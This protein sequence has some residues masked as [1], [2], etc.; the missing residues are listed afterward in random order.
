[1]EQGGRQTAV[2]LLNMGGP[3]S[4]GAVRPFLQNL[5]SDPAIIGLPSL[6][7]GPLA[8]MMAARRARKVRP[9]YELI[10]GKSPIGPITFDQAAALGQA[11]GPAFGPVLPAFS[12]WRPFISDAVDEAARSG[13]GHIVALS[14][15]P[16][17]CMATTGSCLEDVSMNLP[18][19]PF[20]DSIHLIDSWATHPLY[21]DALTA[22][23][24]EA[25]FRVPDNLRDDAIILFSA[26]GVPESLI[27]GGDPYLEQTLATVEGV[28]ERLEGR[29]HHIAFQSRLGPVKW[30]RPSLPDKLKEL[31]TRGA[32]PLVVVPVSFVSDHIETLYELD[33]QHREIATEL[34]FTVYERAPAL[35]VRPDFIRALA[36]LVLSAGP[37]VKGDEYGSNG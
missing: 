4:L 32:P 23:V 31:S 7:R 21:L 36:E 6:L 14:L 28:M 34:G 13:A 10:G 27:E 9:R 29:E 15:Y 25:L 1:M 12:Y 16:Q 3:D 30:L 5:F 11:L 2:L 37:P 33:I 19:T 17:Y 22:T 35:N 20:E 24:N 18:G 8:A 26:H